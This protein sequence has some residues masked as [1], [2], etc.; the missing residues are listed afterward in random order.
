MVLMDLGAEYGYT[1]D[2]TR[3][4][5]ANGT[6]SA[7]QKLIYDLV[8]QAQEWNS[9]FKVELVWCFR[10]NSTLSIKVSKLGVVQ[11]EE[12]ANKYFPRFGSSYWPRRS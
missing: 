12:K 7:E 2:V 3:T 5:P 6:F 8:Y 10:C 4:I 9:S 1:A 11:S